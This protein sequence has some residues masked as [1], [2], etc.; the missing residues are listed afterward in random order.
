MVNSNNNIKVQQN[1]PLLQ[2]NFNVRQ[3]T[4]QIYNQPP[5][6]GNFYNLPPNQQNPTAQ[7][8][9]ELEF[10]NFR[11]IDN[12]QSTDFP[13]FRPPVLP[14]NEVNYVSKPRN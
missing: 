10:A 5:V 8:N 4:N 1:I 13:Q 9:K 11:K 12:P 7:S 6:V 3:D 2:N 14:N